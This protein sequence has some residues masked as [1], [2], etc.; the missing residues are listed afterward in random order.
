MR[1]CIFCGTRGLTKEDA[2][3]LWL[4]RRFN[5]SSGVVVNAARAGLPPAEWRQ[6]SHF[7]K[8]KFV[9]AG[10][11]NGWMSRLENETKSIIESLLEQTT[12]S[13]SPEQQFTLGRWAIKCAM[14]FEALRGSRRWFYNDV[15]RAAFVGG[16]VA[17]GYTNVWY[18]RSEN[19]PGVYCFASDM[20]DSPNPEE[21]LTTGYVTTLAFGN[22]AIQVVSV[23]LSPPEFRP[24]R[25]TTDLR[26]GPWDDLLLRV[27]PPSVGTIWPLAMAFDGEL[28]I[29]SLS[30]RFR[31]KTPSARAT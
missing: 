16:T 27:W 1:T 19:L 5:A 20:S 4:M 6:T 14:V 28:G 29:E 18:G 3:P 30:L 13:L 8:V 2:W 11:N 10:C 9:C 24:N 26:P 23:R 22:L 21:S 15:E 17:L 31:P 25:L 12:E 7:T